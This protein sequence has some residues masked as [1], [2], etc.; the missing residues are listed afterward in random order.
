MKRLFPTVLLTIGTLSVLCVTEATAMESSEFSPGIRV[1][2]IGVQPQLGFA[3]CEHG[4]ADMQALFAD[5]AVIAAPKDLHAQVALPTVDFSDKRA[6]VVH[7]LNEEGC[8]PSRGSS[9]LKRLAFDSTLILLRRPRREWVISKDG[10]KPMD[11]HGLLSDWTL[12][13]ISMNWANSSPIAG[14]CLQLCCSEV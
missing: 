11:S 14:V 1:Q 8:Q 5:P 2:G 10:L 12:G 3:C 6:A 4:I 9:S 7:R 13:R